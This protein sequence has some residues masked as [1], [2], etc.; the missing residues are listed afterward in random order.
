[1][2]A[3]RETPQRSLFIHATF[4]EVSTY[5]M[6][7]WTN[8][9]VSRAYRDYRPCIPRDIFTWIFSH[10]PNDHRFLALDVGCG[11]STF[12]AECLAPNFD[13]VVAVDPSAS[14]LQAAPQGVGNLSYVLGGGAD[15][16]RIVGQ[17]GA[18]SLI[19]VGTA[20]HWIED[21]TKF[22]Q[23]CYSLAQPRGGVL[24]IW[25]YFWSTVEN[26]DAATA[27]IR[28]FTEQHLSWWPRLA[29]HCTDGYVKLVPEV[30]AVWGSGGSFREGMSSRDFSSLEEYLQQVR[31]YSGIVTY[32]RENPT[33]AVAALEKLK[34]D[35]KETLVESVEGNRALF[36]LL[37]PYK[38]WVWTKSQK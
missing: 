33:G 2:T 5:N 18:V 1:M 4:L 28:R 31:T 11:S 13:R 12:S 30:S 38:C 36:T 29:L 14:Q 34:E 27:V 6:S 19:T 35:L 25:C 8:A 26:N 7:H 9:E 17:D 16:L 15:V 21:V 10:V 24:A 23:D 20:L 32:L 37:T 22:A 3:L